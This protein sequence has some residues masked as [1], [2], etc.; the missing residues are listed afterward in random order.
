M[1][2]NEDLLLSILIPVFNYPVGLERILYG[3]N[4]TNTDRYEVLVSDNS[5]DDSIE[6]IIKEWRTKSKFNIIYTK[7]M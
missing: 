4:L 6:K 5:V 2:A 1:N 7:N 3:L